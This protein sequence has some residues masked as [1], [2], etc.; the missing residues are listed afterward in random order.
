MAKAAERYRELRTEESLLTAQLYALRYDA[1]KGELDERES[2]LVRHA[3]LWAS[4]LGPRL[5]EFDP[6][7]LVLGFKI[8]ISTG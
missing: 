3:G 6:C 7:Y 1:L 5:H 8:I 4:L 2:M